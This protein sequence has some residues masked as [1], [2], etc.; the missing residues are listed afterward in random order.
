MADHSLGSVVYALRAVDAAG[1]SVDAERAW[2]TERLPGEVRRLALSALGSERLRRF[3]PT[4]PP[5][6][7][8][9]APDGSAVVLPR[10][11]R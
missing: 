6:S 10:A 3:H 11:G 9:E 2:Q 1:N 8:Q 7:P 5:D 4:T